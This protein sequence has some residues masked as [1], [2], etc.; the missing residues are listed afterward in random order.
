MTQARTKVHLTGSDRLLTRWTVAA[1]I[2]LLAI[3]VFVVI[4]RRNH[5]EGA[6]LAGLAHTAWPF[7]SGAVAGWL[8]VRG[9]RAPTAIRPTGVVVWI[10]CVAVG[11]GLRAATGQGTALAF[12]MV[13]TITLGLFLLGWRALAR[14]LTHRR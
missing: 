14:L 5:D 1:L 13:A 9:W 10:A 6:A 8:A 12:V 11:M 4:G 2:D 7:V 3:V